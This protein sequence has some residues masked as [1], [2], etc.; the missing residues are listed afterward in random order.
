MIK[1]VHRKTL[2]VWLPEHLIR[3]AGDKPET[4]SAV[5]TE[6]RNTDKIMP[7]ETLPAG[8]KG[9]RKLEGLKNIVKRAAP[10]EKGRM[11]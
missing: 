8:T 3:L 6:A 10:Q 7:T 1:R 4:Y 11:M 5:S 2:W 9:N